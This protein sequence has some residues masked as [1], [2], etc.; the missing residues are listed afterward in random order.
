MPGFSF[1]ATLAVGLGAMSTRRFSP[2][3]IALGFVG[4]IA[5]ACAGLVTDSGALAGGGLVGGSVVLGTALANALPARREAVLIALLVL[6]SIDLAWIATGGGGA[7][8]LP[9]NVANLSITYGGRSSSIGTFDLVV[10]AALAAHSRDRGAAAWLAVSPGPIGM[11]LMN[12]Y[13]AWTGASNLA[14]VPFL[15]LGWLIAEGLAS[16]FMTTA[17]SGRPR[18]RDHI[19]D[20]STLGAMP[21]GRPHL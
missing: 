17:R 7:E 20:S 18:S 2:S 10:A 13:V 15:M 11:M 5:V 4:S 1:L 14:L 19:G 16:R 12:G 21:C 6:A 8:G 9:A 3:R